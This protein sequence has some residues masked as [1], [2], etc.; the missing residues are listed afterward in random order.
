MAF[1]LRR[2]TAYRSRRGRRRRKSWIRI[3]RKG[4][5][6]AEVENEQQGQ[7]NECAI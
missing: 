2:V 5:G 4:E 1:T 3:R 7:N 6:G